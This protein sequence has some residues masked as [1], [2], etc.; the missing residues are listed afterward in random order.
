MQG[1]VPATSLMPA[2]AVGEWHSETVPARP[3]ACCPIRAETASLFCARNGRPSKRSPGRPPLRA[4]PSALG[5]S[6]RRF[7]LMCAAAAECPPSPPRTKFAE[8]HEIVRIFPTQGP[9]RTKIPTMSSPAAFDTS[10]GISRLRT[11]RCLKPADFPTSEVPRSASPDSFPGES[12][13][14]YRS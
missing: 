10:K 7:R 13:P 4:A 8:P 2:F 14:R 1:G 9:T 5:C 3:A 12:C 6:D 11:V